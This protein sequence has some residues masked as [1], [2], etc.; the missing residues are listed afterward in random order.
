MSSE[1]EVELWKIWNRENLG[2]YEGKWIAFSG[3][4]LAKADDLPELS[5]QFEDRIKKD[6]SPIFAFVTFEIRV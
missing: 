4:V 1:D 2:D 6:D 3:K 5:R